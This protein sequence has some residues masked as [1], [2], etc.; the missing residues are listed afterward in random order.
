VQVYNEV[1]RVCCASSKTYSAKDEFTIKS[2]CFKMYWK[3][4]D[5]IIEYYVERYLLRK[6]LCYEPCR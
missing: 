4:G 5:F 6:E 1:K 2:G 3:E